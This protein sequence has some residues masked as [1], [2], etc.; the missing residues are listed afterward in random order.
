MWRGASCE[1][2][3][4]WSLFPCCDFSQCIFQSLCRKERPIPVS[5]HSS[6]QPRLWV[7]SY[8]EWV[9]L[10]DLCCYEAW[11][12]P[13]WIVPIDLL[14][15]IRTN[16]MSMQYLVFRSKLSGLHSTP[17]YLYYRQ[18]QRLRFCWHSL[19]VLTCN[20]STLV[21]S[22][23]GSIFLLSY[24]KGSIG[25]SSTRGSVLLCACHRSKV[26]NGH[27]LR[28]RQNFAVFFVALHVWSLWNQE[29]SLSSM[30]YRKSE[31]IDSLSLVMSLWRDKEH[32]LRRSFLS[33]EILR[34]QV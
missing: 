15:E 14:M 29:P 22:V 20:H 33:H 10:A 24:Q 13:D 21:G 7:W 27:E 5:R 12:D 25:Q 9:P 30:S 3:D 16:L 19:H 17:T 2:I 18:K 28:L 34:K 1:Y 26:D 23:S 8:L 31:R 6:L 11:W 32:H 4:E